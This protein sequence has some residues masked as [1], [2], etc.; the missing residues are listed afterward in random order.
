MHIAYAD[1]TASRAI[2]AARRCAG[3]RFR[4]QGRL[5][6]RA[7]DCVGVVIEAAKAVW[8]VERIDVPPYDLSGDQRWVEECCHALGLVPRSNGTWR[9]GD[10]LVFR[11]D[12]ER[13]HLGLA[14]TMGAEQSA[15]LIHAHIGL[16]R[17]VEEPLCAAWRAQLQAVFRIEP[18]RQKGRPSAPWQ[19]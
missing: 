18:N 3:T 6:G 17:V 14:A 11:M 16:R 5:P 12:R 15:S 8:N 9:P 19:H 13:R 1:E 10:V 4:V 7:L 2:A